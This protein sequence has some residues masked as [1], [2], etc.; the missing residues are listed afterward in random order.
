MHAMLGRGTD[1]NDPPTL[2]HKRTALHWVAFNV[3]AEVVDI[4]VKAGASVQALGKGYESPLHVAA[5]R[6]AAFELRARY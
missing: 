5:D 2:A 4:L 6:E 1:V 3:K